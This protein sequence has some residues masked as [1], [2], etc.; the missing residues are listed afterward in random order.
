[1]NDLYLRANRVKAGVADYSNSTT[2]IIAYHLRQGAAGVFKS[3]L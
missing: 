1:V 3:A 2:L